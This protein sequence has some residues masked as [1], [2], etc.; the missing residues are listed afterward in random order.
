MKYFL[1][2][3]PIAGHEQS[4]ECISVNFCEEDYL[5]HLRALVE[6]IYNLDFIIIERS[7]SKQSLQEA[8]KSFF[9]RDFGLSVLKIS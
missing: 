2:I 8:M 1:K 3:N 6:D 9:S 7:L 4:I 5:M